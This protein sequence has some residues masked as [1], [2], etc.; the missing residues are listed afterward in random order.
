MS[1]SGLEEADHSWPLAL[2][3][4]GPQMTA[5]GGVLLKEPLHSP[6][7]R[8]WRVALS[9]SPGSAEEGASGGRCQ[10]QRRSLVKAGL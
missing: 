5:W 3:L 10:N 8:P 4:M 1:W 7:C 6:L 2:L 9:P